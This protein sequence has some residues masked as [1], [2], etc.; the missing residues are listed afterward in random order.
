MSGKAENPSYNRLKG[1]TVKEAKLKST[2]KKPPGISGKAKPVKKWRL[3]Y[4][5]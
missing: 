1:R 3:C 5:S 2:T 4:I